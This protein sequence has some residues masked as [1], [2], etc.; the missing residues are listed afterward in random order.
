MYIET[1]QRLKLSMY[2]ALPRR[3]AQHTAE[4][5]HV[6]KFGLSSPLS[7]QKGSPNAR[8]GGGIV[9]TTA[10]RHRNRKFSR[11]VV[12]VVVGKD[13]TAPR[14][15]RATDRLPNG[16][17]PDCHVTSGGGAPLVVAA[18]PRRGGGQWGGGRPASSVEE[19]RGRLSREE[20]LEVVCHV[21]RK[22]WVERTER[23]LGTSSP[24]LSF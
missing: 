11:K 21:R 5:K 24:L 20:K 1:T 17:R 4:A 18:R 8:G 14:G 16:R 23:T 22:G 7:R 13:S 10:L 6:V 2:G 3:Q 19:G 12:V 15:G 9:A